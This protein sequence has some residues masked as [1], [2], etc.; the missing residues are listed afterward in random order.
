MNSTNEQNIDFFNRFREIKNDL[1]KASL[2]DVTSILNHYNGGPITV[3]GTTYNFQINPLDAACLN[4]RYKELTGQDHPIFTREQGKVLDVAIKEDGNLRVNGAPTIY[5]RLKNNLTGEGV[6]IDII[7]SKKNSYI[8]TYDKIKLNMG[9]ASLEDVK[10]ILDHYDQDAVLI[11]GSTYHFRP[12]ALEGESLNARY[13]ELTGQDH[14]TFAKVQSQVLDKKIK[15]GSSLVVNGEPT[16]YEQLQNKTM[17]MGNNEHIVTRTA[18]ILTNVQNAKLEEVSGLLE[19]Y[20]GKPVLING[21][22]HHTFNEPM[23]AMKLNARYRELTGEDH[24]VYLEQVPKVIDGYME[25]KEVL[26]R[27]GAYNDAYFEQ[28]E[29]IKDGVLLINEA[30]AN[31]GENVTVETV[32]SKV[33]EDSISSEQQVSEEAQQAEEAKQ[34]FMEER[35]KQRDLDASVRSQQIDAM[36]QV[37]QHIQSVQQNTPEA[38]EENSVGGLRR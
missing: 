6:G 34:I 31:S 15:E 18:E 17:I 9:D 19:H 29:Q 35:D 2:E 24:P 11:G 20:N 16:V 38:V 28:L 7:P 32:E 21:V 12:T 4:A 5:Q 23:A 36:E 8:D 37:N 10:N 13:K 27:S 1:D 26:I 3:D 30:R 14:P 22:V 33:T 25:D